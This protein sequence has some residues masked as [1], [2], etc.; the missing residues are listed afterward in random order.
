MK[1]F[2]AGILVGLLGAIGLFLIVKQFQDSPQPVQVKSEPTP[3]P[4]TITKRPDDQRAKDDQLYQSHKKWVG[5]EWEFYGTS[6]KTYIIKVETPV[7]QCPPLQI[8][9]CS[10]PALRSSE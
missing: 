8:T 4:V 2:L 6:H 10:F 3:E 1:N 5:T 7:T 9:A